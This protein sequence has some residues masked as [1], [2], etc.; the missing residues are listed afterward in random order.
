MSTAHEME[1]ANQ[2]LPREGTEEKGTGREAGDLGFISGL[3]HCDLHISLAPLKME[4]TPTLK[5]DP[6]KQSTQIL[7]ACGG[8]RCSGHSI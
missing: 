2:N 5:C 6:R 4:E 1:P 8:S 3:S 7:V